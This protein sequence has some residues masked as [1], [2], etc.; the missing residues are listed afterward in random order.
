M[1][2]FSIKEAFS[3]GWQEFKSRPWF[4]VGLM[5]IVFVISAVISLIVQNTGDVIGG[6]LQIVGTVVQWWLYIGIIMIAL[7][8][9]NKQSPEFGMLFKGSG[10][11]LWNYVLG[12]IL[13]TLVVLVGLVL[14][15]FPGIIWGIKFHYYSFLIV[16]KGMKPMDA[17]KRSGAITMGYKWKLF[18]LFILI[19]LLNLAG[20]IVLGVGLLVTMPVSLLIT[21]F[22]Y[23]L[24]E[25]GKGMVYATSSPATVEPMQEQ[26]SVATS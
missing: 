7:A 18:G 21:V 25:D 4:F 11:T 13:Y 23:K 16:D 26:S 9:Y 3:W 20:A 1:K 2:E 15:V 19:G 6:V 22:V 17:L 14:F 10:K 12:T 24:L 8:V 5:L